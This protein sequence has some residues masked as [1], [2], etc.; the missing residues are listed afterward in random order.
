MARFLDQSPEACLVQSRCLLEGSNRKCQA[1][2]FGV[3]LAFS[4]LL[5]CYLPCAQ[6][7]A[8]QS[9][10]FPEGVRVLDLDGQPVDPFAANQAKAVV[11]I[12]VGLDCPISNGYMPEYQRLNQEF[13]D[14][15]LRLVYPNMD[16]SASAIRKR[17][18]E[19]HC[20][21]QTLRDPR[22]ELVKMT[23]ARVTPEAAVFAAGRGLVY[24]GRI[25][26]RYFDLG[27][28]RP[29]ATSHDLKEVL[30]AISAGK[31]PGPRTTRAVGCYI[32]ELP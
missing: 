18:Q 30:E 17:L 6:S 27:K 24:R 13:K 25:D 26:D 19:Y 15:V 5:A 28:A 23:E 9:T 8:P 2:S 14:I 21:V 1:S 22:H 29:A 16:E 10:L 12:F 20:S 11:F 31:P 32:S 3:G 7:A 4:F